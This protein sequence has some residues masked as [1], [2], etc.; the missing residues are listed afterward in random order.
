[1]DDKKKFQELSDLK[2]LI[3]SEPFQKHIMQPL[4]KKLDDLKYAYDCD[5]LKE[6]QAMKGKRQGLRTI[7]ELLKGVNNEWVNLK[8]ELKNSES[9]S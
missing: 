6:L 7:I 2:F 3:E 5:S 4:Q 1:M 9:E 8:E